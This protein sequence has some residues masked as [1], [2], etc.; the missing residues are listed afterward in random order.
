MGSTVYHL[1][2]ALAAKGHTVTVITRSGGGK[3]PRVDGVTVAEVPWARIPMEF[4]RSY[5]R[6][7]LRALEKLHDREPVDVIHVHAPLLA[8]NEKQ[9]KR[10]RGISPVITSLH[11]SWKGEARGLVLGSQ[12]GEEGARWNVND[13]AIRRFANHYA[14][15]ENIAINHSDICVANSVATRNDF[16]TN[17]SPPNNWDCETILWGVD[18][19]LYR[20]LHLDSEDD[21]VRSNELRKR[22]G[23]DQETNLILAVGR[24][25]ARKGHTMLIRAFAKVVKESPD[26]HLLIVG[27]GGLRSKLLRLARV[28]GI[29]E[30]V[31]IESGMSFE[32]LGECLSIS[33]LVCYPS[34]YEG[35]GLVPLEAMAAGTPC[36]TFDLPPLTEMIDGEVGGLC[37]MSEDSLAESM[38]S[39]LSS[40]ELIA[41]GAAGRRRVLDLFT[42]EGNADAFLAVYERAI[43][44]SGRRGNS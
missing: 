12:F 21:F 40:G 30:H 16:E 2:A 32:E 34:Y 33:D 7:A 1:S 43:G 24:L 41:K 27:R 10:A 15:F 35:Q 3:P 20:P 29:N 25:A 37:E 6:W 26:S 11:G 19:G 39:M 17:Y 8:W 31:S 9:F 38:L 22:Y 4:T 18:T 13:I 14:K 28:L 5:G 36:L 42:L 44:D 23:A